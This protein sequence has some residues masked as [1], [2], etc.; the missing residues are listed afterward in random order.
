[1]S[2]PIEVEEVPCPDCGGRDGVEVARGPD[3]DEHL[4]GDQE[5]RLVRCRECDVC[6]LNPRPTAAMLPVIYDSEQYYAYGLAESEPSVIRR[7]RERRNDGKAASLLELISR[8]PAQ[9]RVFEI[10]PGDGG[11]LQAFVRAG[12]PPDHLTGI[13]LEE[14]AIEN[15][16]QLGIPGV[17]GRVEDL[18]ADA[19]SCDV[20]LMIQTI[21]H[22]DR[23][24]EVLRS[25]RRRL[26]PGGLFLIETPNLASWD[27][28]LFRRKTWGGYHFP[29]HWTLWTPDT[30]IRLLEETGFE[31]R[32]VTTPN[33]AVLGAW[34][35]RHVVEELG[36]GER[37]TAFF[38][39]RNP[40]WLALLYAIDLVPSLLGRSANMRVV[41]RVPAEAETA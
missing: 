31:I 24:R 19:A 18:D 17:V 8:P 3:Y 16:R 33:S 25:V 9:L 23:P 34:S 13:D 39:D 20:A 1:M 30:L 29:R 40:A 36:L 7:M 15:L 41:A 4:C 6:Y 11:L 26:A 28:K 37:A 32:S 2:G 35:T 5:F 27:R 12:V 14:R 38:S 10:G 21:E 22:V